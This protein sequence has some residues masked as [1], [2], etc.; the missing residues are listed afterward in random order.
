MKKLLEAITRFAS[1]PEQK[2]GDQVRG[3]E[4]AKSS[5]GNKHPFQGRL[6]GASESTTPHEN[7][8]K[9][10]SEVADN[11]EL[12]W[13]LMEEFNR[14]VEEQENIGTKEKRS[15]RK[16]SR[17][18]R[19][20]DESVLEEAT[21]ETMWQ[22]W[23][24]R[25][26]TK[27]QFEGQPV[28]WM[29]WNSKRSTTDAH[30]G[31][32]AT[33]EE[34]I[35]AA[36]EWI[37]SG[38]NAKE[39]TS[40]V[41]IDFNVDFANKIVNG[42]THFFAKIVAGPTLVISNDPAPG[43]KTSAVR[44]QAGRATQGT[45]LLPVITL[46]VKEARDAGLKAHGRYIVGDSVRNQDGT[47][48][49]P[50]IYQTTVQD[51]SDKLH[52]RQPGLTVAMNRTPAAKSIDEGYLDYRGPDDRVQLP[53][54]PHAYW[55]NAGALQAEYDKLYNELVP[56]SG[57]ADT[58]EGEVLR[59]AS[60]IY[61][62]H[63][64]DG[65][66]F[67]QASFNQLEPYIGQ[68][69][70]YD[71][72]AQ[73]ATEF[74]LKANGNYTP[75]T[76]WN[77]LDVMEYGPEEDEGDWYRDEDEDDED[78][79]NWE[80]ED[81]L[82]EVASADE[83]KA[84]RDLYNKIK[85]KG[86][87][88][89]IDRDR[90]TDL[91]HEGLEGPF[92]AKN[93]EVLYYDPKAGKYYNRDSDMY[94]DHGL[95]EGWGAEKQKQDLEQSM[96]AWQ[97]MHAKYAND[98]EAQIVL[99]M[100]HRGGWNAASAE[101]ELLGAPGAKH[102]KQF[103]LDYAA[104]KGLTE[105]ETN[106]AIEAYGVKGMKST[107]WRK[108]FKNQQAFERWLDANEGNVEVHGTRDVA[109]KETFREGIESADPTEGAVL[110]AVQELIQQ[111]HT[112][113]APEVITNMVVAATGKPFLLKDL[114]DANN[115]SQA[116]QH[117]VDSINPS[118]VKFSNEILTVKNEDPMKEKQAAQDGVSKMAAKAASR[119]RLGE[120]AE[121][122]K[123]SRLAELHSRYQSLKEQIKC[124]KESRGHEVIKRKLQD[125]ERQEAPAG[126]TD[127][128]KRAARAKAE[129]AKYVAKMKKKNPDYVPMYKMDEEDLNEYGANQPTGTAAPGAMQV[130][131]PAQARNVA[132]AASTIK[133]ATGASATPANLAKAID[134]ASQ[135]KPVGQ[136][137][138][139]A[140]DPVMDV[141]SQATQDPKLAN[142]FR[143]LAQQAKTSAAQQK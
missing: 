114:V 100:L 92:R 47:I 86:V 127:L 93:G 83:R 143:T 107:P 68:V 13:A 1:E 85:S 88:P 56:S 39:I 72:L 62:R 40:N 53:D 110:L 104:K 138:M 75:N 135:G 38:G 89:S 61:Y 51:K 22:G 29:T 23:K 111:G 32:A 126:E 87:V 101:K 91:S 109:Q 11:K 64:N 141:I 12:E 44:T 20:K 112:E 119:P 34:A 25:Y 27:P 76:D 103:W 3:T 42:N 129:Y 31:S 118:K 121:D 60:K 94:V 131:D 8:L 90:Y 139:A 113:V 99:N 74:A 43:F 57:K 120:S 115:N 59:A 80:D 14:F 33:P 137:D 116:I 9:D 128:E 123:A 5:K 124:Y 48:S 37:Q 97:A 78:D 46:S 65:D 49:F 102:N 6:V 2:P 17:T 132:Q 35:I 19:K 45:T 54:E 52:M 125:I 133:S 77:S 136:K 7:M 70:S 73:K 134:S 108:T 63:Y 106:S 69:T 84:N 28:R 10:L 96:A 71:D 50:L 66:S 41:T 55:S 122:S 4:K 95:D 79:T 18:S 58:V 81:D 26:E 21:Q 24:I 16:G 105:N 117:Y 15:T 30:E 82:V 36:K 130:N 98:A 67:N 142:Q 140:L